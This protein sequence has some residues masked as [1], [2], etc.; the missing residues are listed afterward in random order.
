MIKSGQTSEDLIYQ[1]LVGLK[2][3]LSGPQSIPTILKNDDCDSSISISENE[4]DGFEE[5]SKF[6]N[7]SR[8]KN[9]DSESKRVKFQLVHGLCKVFY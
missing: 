4:S 5:K 8:P 7:S 1:K 3:D 9:E 2:E 6:Y